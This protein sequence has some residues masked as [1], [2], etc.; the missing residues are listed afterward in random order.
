MNIERI[1]HH[2]CDLA[3]M[4]LAADS[5]SPMPITLRLK[6]P[7]TVPLEAEV[8]TPDVL[9]SLSHAEIAALTVYHGKRQLPLS[10]FFEIDGERSADLVLHGDL[11]KV[12]LG[13]SAR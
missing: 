9:A 6:Q 10:E 13:R 7:P 5:V 1:E 3:S 11:H 4:C 8:L 12:R 2:E